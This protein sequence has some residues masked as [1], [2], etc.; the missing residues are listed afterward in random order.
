MHMHPEEFADIQHAL[1]LSDNELSDVLGLSKDSGPRMIRRM[2]TGDVS[3]SGPIAT[4][5][6]A[7]EDGFR[8]DG[9]P[10]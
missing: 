1:D 7:F 5:M 9:W 4:C 2:K 8:P 3:I 6:F 10:D